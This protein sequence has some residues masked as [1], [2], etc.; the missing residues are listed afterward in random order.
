[1]TGS[2]HCMIAPYWCEK[3]GKNTLNCF[4]ASSRSGSLV[5]TLNKNIV[6]I[7][8]KAKLYANCEILNYNTI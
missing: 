4:Q 1:M 5:A 2:A 7:S 3:L 8:G 6:I